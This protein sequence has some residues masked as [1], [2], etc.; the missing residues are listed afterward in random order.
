MYDSS[1][2]ETSVRVVE[3]LT[4]ED[5]KITTS[6]LVTDAAAFIAFMGRQ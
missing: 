6:T 4:V 5:G 3:R 2:S 1:R